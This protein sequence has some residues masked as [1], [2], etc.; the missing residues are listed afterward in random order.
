MNKSYQV[1]SNGK[2]IDVIHINPED[3]EDY[4]TFYIDQ[5]GD[6]NVEILP[7]PHLRVVWVDDCKDP[8]YSIL[9]NNFNGVKI[10]R[11]Y[12]EA[13]YHLSFG[14]DELYLDYDLG[15][16]QTGADVLQYLIDH[17]RVP[18]VQFITLNPVGRRTMETMLKNY[19]ERES[20]LI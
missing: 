5:T 7:Y 20:T 11:S 16:S 10:A 13:L 17:D 2:C 1:I 8:P 3:I 15:G 18:H 19:N 14:C 4:F 9:H 6:A 12:C